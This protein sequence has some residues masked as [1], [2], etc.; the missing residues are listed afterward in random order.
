MNLAIALEVSLIELLTGQSRP[1]S[2]LW[3]R[4][5]VLEK[6]VKNIRELASSF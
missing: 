2:E 5:I 3:E 6:A 4:L 1:E